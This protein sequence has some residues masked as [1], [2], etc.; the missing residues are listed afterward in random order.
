MILTRPS[1]VTLM[2]PGPMLRSR[3][4]HTL[5]MLPWPVRPSNSKRLLMSTIGSLFFG[6][7]EN[8]FFRLVKTPTKHSRIFPRRWARAPN[9]LVF[10]IV[11]EARHFRPQ[12]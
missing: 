1:W 10:A 2:L 12:V 4:R 11:D 3:A 5:D 7:P 6:F 8:S 9:L